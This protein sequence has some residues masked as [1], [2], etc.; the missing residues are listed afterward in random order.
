MS[1]WQLP[2]AAAGLAALISLIEVAAQWRRF[3]YPRVYPFILVRLIAQAGTAVLAYG[4]ILLLFKGVPWLD[5]PIPIIVSGIS[6]PAIV[7]NQLALIGRGRGGLLDDPAGR[8]RRILGWID[9]QIIDASIAAEA[10]WVVHTAMPAVRKLALSD[11]HDQAK[12]YVTK[13]DRLTPAAKKRE[14]TFLRQTMAE[15]ATTDADKCKAIVFRLLEI[16]ARGLVAHMMR[17]AKT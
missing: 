9:S 10:T 12:F 5:G 11:V 13:T 2:T 6:G 1:A 16:D 3:I 7:R 14:L 17:A 15:A 8:Y 4:I